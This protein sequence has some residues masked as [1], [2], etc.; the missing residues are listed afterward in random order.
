V[1]IE[2]EKLVGNVL[3]A[4]TRQSRRCGKAL[5]CCSVAPGAIPDW[6]GLASMQGATGGQKDRKDR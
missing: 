1:A 4:L 2:I 3:L 5:C 6:Q